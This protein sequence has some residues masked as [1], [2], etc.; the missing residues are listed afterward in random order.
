MEACAE[1]LYL[2]DE[3]I[4]KV[5]RQRREEATQASDNPKVIPMPFIQ[6]TPDKG[7][8]IVTNDWYVKEEKKKLAKQAKTKKEIQIEMMKLIAQKDQINTKL[9]ELDPSKKKDAKKIVYCNIKLKDIDAELK[10]LQDQSGIN[11]NKLE[12]GSKFSR[13]IGWFKRKWKKFKKG[14]KNFYNTYRDPLT[15]LFTVAIPAIFTGIIRGIIH[16]VSRK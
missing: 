2:D 6:G 16:L 12:H 3:D 8:L 13:F 11:L 5:F 4:P 9:G 10:M 15:T 7:P 14:V 1:S